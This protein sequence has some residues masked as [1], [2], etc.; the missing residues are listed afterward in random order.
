MARRTVPRSARYNGNNGGPGRHDRPTDAP[1]GA[2]GR[3][4]QQQPT[5]RTTQPITPTVGGPYGSSQASIEAQH[6]M[7]V[8]GGVPVPTP[9]P[10]QP[11]PYLGDPNAEQLAAAAAAAPSAQDLL[12][13]PSIRPDED[14]F[15]GL[16]MAAAPRVRTDRVTSM[17]ESIA[18]ATQDPSIAQLAEVARRRGV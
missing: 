3:S 13:A 15:A 2:G 7:P 4:D 9:G 8:A 17:L 1:P 6:V 16:G 14:V 18:R 10:V 12:T 11:Q 5:T